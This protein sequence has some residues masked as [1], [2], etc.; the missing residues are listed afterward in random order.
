MAEEIEE[1]IVDEEIEEE[2]PQDEVDEIEEPE[3]SEEADDLPEEEDDDLPDDDPPSEEEESWVTPDVLSLAQGYGL[4]ESDLELFDGQRDLERHLRLVER[5]VSAPEQEKPK[6][7]EPVSDEEYKDPFDL[8]DFE[9]YPE[10]DR[11]FIEVLNAQA[12]KNH[13]IER[14]NQAIESRLE[15][16]QQQ[17]YFDHFHA[18]ADSLNSEFIGQ[19]VGE[20]GRYAELS[21]EQLANREKL[22]NAYEVIETNMARVQKAKG[23]DVRLPPMQVIMRQALN[24]AFAPE[25]AKAESKERAK[26]LTAQSRRRRPSNSTASASR[27][28]GPP[29]ENDPDFA[30]AVLKGLDPGL[31]KKINRARKR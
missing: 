23:L 14:R 5:Q 27:P 19:T 18:T 7:E 1:D 12:R 25:K 6:G 20:D 21:K 28:A 3:E 29:D 8:A 15:A 13:E 16:Q 31:K 26:K 17:Q 9:D 4:T 10:N 11:K 30:K 24:T 22:W 2:Q